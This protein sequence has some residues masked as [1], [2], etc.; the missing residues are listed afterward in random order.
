[1]FF[2]TL[3]CLLSIGYG[4]QNESIGIDTGIKNYQT[5]PRPSPKSMLV[6]QFS[7]CTEQARLTGLVLILGS[8]S[9]F[10]KRK[11]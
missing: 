10:M 4:Y 2:R 8:N 7:M 3:I 11:K 9:C 5:I 1:M 6:L